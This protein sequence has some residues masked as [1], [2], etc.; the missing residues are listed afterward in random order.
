MNTNQD[1]R[2]GKAVQEKIDSYS[3]YSIRRGL[4]LAREVHPEFINADEKLTISDSL[5]NRVIDY[6]NLEDYALGIKNYLLGNKKLALNY[7]NKVISFR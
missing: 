1:S 6:D 5:E 7:F 3:S 2:I 4:L